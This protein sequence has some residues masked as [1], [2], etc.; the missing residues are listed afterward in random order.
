MFL[1]LD[2]SDVEKLLSGRLLP[3]LRFGFVSLAALG[4]VPVSDDN[5]KE[6]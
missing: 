5:L 4:E 6:S 3:E 2:M 1:V